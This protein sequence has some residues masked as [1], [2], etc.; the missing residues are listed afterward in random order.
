MSGYNHQTGMSNNAVSA[1]DKG[2]KPLSKINSQDLKSANLTITKEFAVW[3]AK[4]HYWPPA[5]WHHSGGTWYNKVDFYDPCKLADLI[6][7]HEIDIDAL[8]TQFDQLGKNET[9]P[10]GRRVRGSFVIWGG[11]RKHPAKIGDK[12]F[13]GTKFGNWI[14][15]DGGGK[16]RADGNHIT[17]R[18]IE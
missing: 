16:K 17:W 3:L 18:Y 10:T 7:D 2:L 13:T 4:N 8:K 5:E 14:H 12:E 9:T 11:S 6:N 1:Y 15:L